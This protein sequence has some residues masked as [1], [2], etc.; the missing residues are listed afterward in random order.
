MKVL[1]VGSGGREHAI[2]YSV[3]KSTKAVS[4]THLWP[5]KE[6]TINYIRVFLNCL[7]KRKCPISPLVHGIE[8][9]YVPGVFFM[10]L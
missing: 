2:A 8:N 3:S 9:F 7:D 1:I 5:K 4:Y 6:N 10:V